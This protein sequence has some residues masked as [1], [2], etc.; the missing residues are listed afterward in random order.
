MSMSSAQPD[1]QRL[2]SPFVVAAFGLLVGLM[3][4]LAF[5]RERL[6]ERLLEG[7][8]VD[9]LTVAYLEA[10]L[11]IEPDNA[12]VLTEL[13]QEYLKA[14][15]IADAQRML[16]RL[17]VSSDPQAQSSALRTR[18]DL[19]ETQAYALKPGDPHRAARLAELDALL[20]DALDKPWDAA[21][22]ETFAKKARALNDSALAG[23]YYE[24][25]ARMEPAQAPRWLAQGA[26]LK[27][28]AGDYAGAA[29]AFFAA[30][31]HAA[32][33]DDERRLFLS[34]LQALQSANRPA[35]AL[36]AADAHLGSLSR[37]RETLRYL[38]RLAL[39]AGRPDI[40]DRYARR[41]LDMSS[42]ERRDGV[43]RLAGWGR[44][45]E[46]VRLAEGVR[47]VRSGTSVG[48]AGN[49]LLVVGP[50]DAGS[51]LNAADATSARNAASAAN[52]KSMQN[53]V[54][55]VNASPAVSA[56]H[57]GS[58]LN[59]GTVGN[60][61]NEA[62]VVS[63]A[64]ARSAKSAMSAANAA[65]AANAKSMQNAVFAANASPA[66][67]VAHAAS[68]LNVG[69]VGNAANEASA[70][71][72]SYVSTAAPAISAAKNTT[73]ATK[74]KTAV[75][76]APFLCTRACMNGR[77]HAIPAVLRARDA[78]SILRVAN[79]EPSAPIE[80][81]DY[82]LGFKVFL[83]NGDLASAQR[84]AQDAV[85]RDP[86]ST[87]WRERL[88]QVA[89][90]NHAPDVALANYLA[91]A[92]ARN[93]ERDW[94]QVQRLA[95]AL[96]DNDAM[97]AAAIH[98]SDRAP[99]DMKRLDRVVSAY[100]AQ[101]DP[102]AALRFLQTRANGAYRRPV[103]ER[104][105]RLAERKGDDDLAIATYE[106]LMRE[107][108]PDSA[109]ALKLSLMYYTRTQFDRSLAVLDSAKSRAP[110][111]DADF[112]R[113]Y[114][115][116]ATVDQQDG[117]AREGYGKLV[118][119]GVATPDDLSAMVS[120]YDN[121]PLEAG[122]IAEFAYRKT[123]NERL[124]E[125]AVYDYLRARATGRIRALLAS[126]DPASLAA[127]E[128]S[129]RFLLARAQ[130]L[131]RAGD[132]DGALADTRAAA[133]LAPGDDEARAAL[134]WALNERG[135]N[136]EL[137]AMLARHARDA[138]RDSTL[139]A[140]YAASYL[141]LGDARGALHMMHK[142]AA[143]RRDDPLWALGYADALELNGRIDDAWRV[144]NAVWKK[145]MAQRAEGKQPV[146]LD[147]EQREDLRARMVG[148]TDQF[149]GGD[150][151]RQVLIE[152]LRAD[153]GDS[154][155]DEPAQPP[156][157]FT[158][159]AMQ[160]VAHREEKRRRV[161]SAVAREAALGWLQ[162]HDAYDAESLWLLR[163]YIDSATRPVYAEVTIAL[164]E[165][166]RATLNRL[167]DTEAD[168]IPRQNRLDAEA[169]TGRFGDVQ[170]HAYEQQFAL[171][172][173]EIVNQILREQLL[174]N[175]Q[176][177]AP[178][179]RVVEQGGLSYTEA[180]IGAGLRLSP[181]QSLAL[182]YA[183]RNQHGDASLPN[184]PRHDRQLSLA[185]RHLGLD[186]T[187]R[188]RIGRRNALDD[189]TTFRL[190]GTLFEQ[191]NLSFN[192]ALGF[193]QMAT[194]TSQ[195]IV[196]GVKHLASVGVNYRPD[197]HVFA[198]GRVEYARFY[199]QDK[200][201]LGTGAVADF[202][203][204][205][206]LRVDYPD[207]TVRAVL[208][209]GQ[210][211]ASG[212]PGGQLARLL[213]AGAPLTAQQFMPQTFTQEGLLFSFGDDLE[214]GYTRAW[215]PFFAA[216]PIHDSNQGWTAQVRVGLAGSVF[217]NDQATM[218]YEHAGVTS[219]RTQAFTEYG[220]RYRWLY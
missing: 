125:L 213:P 22:M 175:A 8:Q 140:P 142:E 75:S 182:D 103:L 53:A 52:A 2:F 151:S 179:F 116:L 118:Q 132:P 57:A 19:A 110:A 180:G 80:A 59:A 96:G 20:A 217:G 26:Q 9:T 27:L 95:P 49:A 177:I 99:G 209:H 196:G 28:A 160:S 21:Q 198:G 192:Y 5:P 152:L 126:L 168:W 54:F 101:A 150:A 76:Q 108:G 63:A 138:E 47:N 11:R 141:R 61:A 112:W 64:E 82:E 191:Q 214:E 25:L 50:G 120:L 72:A 127:A 113:F 86:A 220:V 162:S 83:A 29:D 45:R 77:A 67:S 114:A 201:F 68:V 121:Q 165:H 104:Y 202:N 146:T 134:I 153:V 156:F 81:S 170:T 172:D 203:A 194:E 207:Y 147:D 31:A 181:T 78:F 124:L 206:K 32:T 205:Y 60:A 100:E 159:D 218:Y 90:W 173:D 176:A 211:S 62:S 13:T 137:R 23:R 149:A 85:K 10:W 12:E 87:E 46:A 130:Y 185:W 84:V 199:G 44:G 66:V 74:P 102:D 73:N 195:L 7:R 193:N 30:Q 133:A 88:A 129:P 135:S 14:Q 4:V 105:A 174:R 35:D 163:Q 98:E 117:K 48:N 178:R 58:V 39:S 65:N 40:A 107:F 169:T 97:L 145:Q 154:A 157:A 51:G 204:G 56:A 33:R 186:D 119:A 189:F 167:L 123:G 36:A 16:R 212:N 188:V 215:R 166:D 24:R 71:R 115:M 144:R 42:R 131:R 94:K 158:D 161:Y 38:T 55:A 208:T 111:P 210:Y 34:A 70:L 219:G 143:S 3:L 89:E 92:R 128:R 139:W 109:Y 187:E 200:S 79:Q 136:A 15:R 6:E 41:L 37:D 164:A 190:D 93:G 148:L 122:R 171:P 184:V 43:S 216:G 106:R 91:L 69:T 155:D 17:S 18:I 197:P 1:R 183:D